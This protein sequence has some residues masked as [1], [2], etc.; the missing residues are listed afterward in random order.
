MTSSMDGGSI[1]SPIYQIIFC[2]S[3]S[4]SFRHLKVPSSLSDLV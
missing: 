1:N 2:E 3:F 4:K